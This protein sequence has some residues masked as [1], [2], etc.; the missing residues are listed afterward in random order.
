LLELLT[1]EAEVAIVDSA[2][3]RSASQAEGCRHV[4]THLPKV[5]PVIPL[6][7]SKDRSKEGF[8]PVLVY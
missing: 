3:R 1:L 5:E 8:H 7:L 4:S 6:T 2:D